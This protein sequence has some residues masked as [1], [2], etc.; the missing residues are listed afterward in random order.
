MVK[1]FSLKKNSPPLY[2]RA[3]SGLS[4]NETESPPL[5]ASRVTEETWPILHPEPVNFNQTI[6]QE[7][8]LKILREKN[9][10][11]VFCRSPCRDPFVNTCAPADQYFTTGRSD[12]LTTRKQ[13]AKTSN[14]STKNCKKRAN[15]WPKIREWTTR[16]RWS[17]PPPPGT[18]LKVTMTAK[19]WNNPAGTLDL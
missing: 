13:R 11:V 1:K 5:H 6:V 15:G 2:S 17:R 14:K 7:R 10:S 3:S 8:T 16:C 18:P 12:E 19:Y 9:Y 4:Y